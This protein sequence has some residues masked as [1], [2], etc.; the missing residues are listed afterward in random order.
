MANLS[1]QGL[2]VPLQI[3]KGP[4]LLSPPANQILVTHSH[5]PWVGVAWWRSKI[6]TKSARE[7]VANLSLQ[8]L[9]VPLQIAKAPTLL[10]PPAN[11]ISEMR[12]EI[13]KS[14]AH[15]QQ[16]TAIRKHSA[17]NQHTHLAYS[18]KLPL[19]RPIR[20]PIPERTQNVNE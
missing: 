13:R 8:G 18:P 10:S 5:T 19:A 2:Q 12:N 4:T 17:R 1:S 11:Q 9:Q 16:R 20:R 7:K 15:T 3:A 6:R 14:G